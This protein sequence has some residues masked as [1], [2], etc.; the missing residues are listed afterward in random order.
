MLKI[1]ALITVSALMLASLASVPVLAAYCGHDEQAGGTYCSMKVASGTPDSDASSAALATKYVEYCREDEFDGAAACIIVKEEQETLDVE[2]EF[3][4][5]FDG[6]W[7][8]V[9][10][11]YFDQM[12]ELNKSLEIKV[13]EGPVRSFKS[14]GGSAVYRGEDD[15]VT[16]RELFYVDMPL[17][18][19]IAAARTRVWFR[20]KHED[21]AQR[22]LQMEASAFSPLKRFIAEAS[23]AF[24][25]PA[26]GD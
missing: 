20:L 3:Q 2:I 10:S 9:I 15:I 11:S 4:R 7:L 22:D 14:A 13:D 25:E 17:L 6:A 12:E 16:V 5:G 24:G 1:E 19:G 21:G 18:E 8:L 26:P 23:S